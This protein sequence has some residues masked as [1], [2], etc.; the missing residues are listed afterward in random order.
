MPSAHGAKKEIKI[1]METDPDCNPP[2]Q[3]KQQD[4]LSQSIAELQSPNQVKRLLAQLYDEGDYFHYLRYQ[5]KGTLYAKKE[6][7]RQEGLSFHSSHLESIACQ[8][9]GYNA[10]GLGVAT[11]VGSFETMKTRTEECCTKLKA[12][13]IDIDGKNIKALDLVGRPLEE[14]AEVLVTKL[15]AQGLTPHM[16]VNSG[17]GLHVYLLLESMLMTTETQRLHA[18]GVWYSLCKVIGGATDRFD[19]ASIMRVPGTVN[20]KYNGLIPVR[21]FESFTD[22]K[23]PR[24]KLEDIEAAVGCEKVVIGKTKKH[25]K[26]SSGTVPMSSSS[27]GIQPISRPLSQEHQ[28]LLDAALKLDEVQKA[29][30]PNLK[31]SKDL[32]QLRAQTLDPSPKIDHSKADFAYG[33]RLLQCG[34]PDEVV[35]GELQNGVK[36]HTVADA[37]YYCQHTLG[38]LETAVE[39]AETAIDTRAWRVASVAEATTHKYYIEFSDGMPVDSPCEEPESPT[40]QVSVVCERPGMGKTHQLVEWLTRQGGTYHDG[41][42]RLVLGEFKRELLPYEAR[43]NCLYPFGRLDPYG[44]S[45]RERDI[46]LPNDNQDL[47]KRLGLK[48]GSAEYKAALAT[49]DPGG[50]YLNTRHPLVADE[51]RFQDDE[52]D[53]ENAYRDSVGET[54]QPRMTEKVILPPFAVVKFRGTTEYCLAGHSKGVLDSRKPPCGTTCSYGSCRANSTTIEDSVPGSKTYWKG[55]QV[56]LLTHQGYAVQQMLVSERNDFDEIWCDEL[57]PLVFRRPTFTIMRVRDDRGIHWSVYPLDGLIRFAEK[58]N[59]Y[60]GMRQRDRLTSI[61]DKLEDRREKWIKQAQNRERLANVLQKKS[62]PAYDLARTDR[63]EPL[64]SLEDF[65]FLL[66]QSQRVAHLENVPEDLFDVENTPDEDRESPHASTKALCMLKD[67]CDGSNGNLNVFLWFGK[68]KEEP[69]LKITRPVNGWK[70]LLGP[71]NPKVTILDATAGIDPRYLTAGQFAKE[72]YPKAEFP[73]TK[74]VLMPPRSKTGVRKLGVDDL[75]TEIKEQVAAYLDCQDSLLVLTN[76]ENEEKLVGRIDVPGYLQL[77][78]VRV[79]HF[80]NL[81]GRNDFGKFSA[82]YFTNL[83][84]Y[85]PD[86]YSCLGLLADGFD[87]GRA[88]KNVGKTVK[89]SGISSDWIPRNSWKRWDSIEARAI[90]SDIY[91]DALR[92]RIRT[93]PNAPALIFLPTYDSAVVTRLMRLMPGAGFQVAN[94][95]VLRPCLG[96]DWE[97]AFRQDERS[98]VKIVPGSPGCFYPVDAQGPESVMAAQTPPS[99]DNATEAIGSVGCCD[100]GEIEPLP[101]GFSVPSGDKWQR[102]SN[103]QTPEHDS[104]ETR[105]REG[106]TA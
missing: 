48:V 26:D 90:V 29:N 32:N 83:Y 60:A 74:V 41:I 27:D 45:F 103:V 85:E 66:G 105:P 9:L 91:Q 101:A 13:A 62:E 57:P 4:T 14:V 100:D 54:P 30:T 2:D 17:H 15:N 97:P 25:R 86:Y 102:R 23:L 37:D 88:G 96:G 68:S 81:R 65:T 94:G 99:N 24:Y 36:A 3:T 73:N 11:S 72:S 77:K 46:L 22:E 16:V 43:I 20:C 33:S 8:I 71:S 58:V 95:P 38:K 12:L 18:K 19:L 61:V 21:F 64:L 28:Q 82:V 106:M 40:G 93:D 42:R 89:E 56:A 75:V 84:R 6:R 79:A 55:A 39:I 63:I 70:E 1:N 78:E 80:G 34:M 87:L 53:L 7:P 59:Q 69:V 35:L 92:I 67:F 47:V 104:V 31:G 50:F 10:L 98:C 44:D 76:L 5:E 52:E 49:P 51:R